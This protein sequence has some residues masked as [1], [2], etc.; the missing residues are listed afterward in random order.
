MDKETCKAHT[1]PFC[2]VVPFFSVLDTALLFTGAGIDKEA[3]QF[4]RL[5]SCLSP[6]LNKCKVYV[7]RNKFTLVLDAAKPK[8]VQKFLLSTE[9]YVSEKGHQR[10]ISSCQAEGSTAA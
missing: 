7:K 5:L 3:K 8:N 9:A 10:G 6:A 1:D 4:N 2:S